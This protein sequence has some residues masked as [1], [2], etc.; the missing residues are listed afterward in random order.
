MDDF[1]AALDFM[2]ARYPGRA[3]VGRRLLVRRVGRADGRRARPSRVDAHRHRAA[4][5]QVRLRGVSP[6]ARSRSSSSTAR[7]DEICPLKAHMRAFYATLRRA[8]GAGGH[9]RRRPPV[10]RAGRAKSAT[11]L[12]DSARRDSPRMTTMTGRRHRLR[13]AHRRSARRRTARC[14]P[15]APTNSPRS[16]SREALR[17]A[18]GLDPAEIDDVILGCAMPEAEQG[19]N[20]ARI[21]SLRA[22][23]PVTRVGRHGEPLL[24]VRPAGDRLR[25]RAHHVRLRRRSSIAGGTESMS[26]VPMGGNKVAPNPALVDTLPG[27]VP[28][29]RA[30][31]PRTTRAS[32]RSRARSRTRSRSRSH[33]RALAAIDAGRFADEIVP[34]PSACVRPANGTKPRSTT[35]CSRRRGPAARHLARGAREAAA[36]VPRQPAPSRPA[37]RRR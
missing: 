14:A 37:T 19:L 35:S 30:S 7:R 21:A 12:E 16:S 11:P 20:V 17:R 32:R 4:G 24:L 23:V 29:H 18:P 13:R 33:Q 25:R 28:Q 8:E 5:R 26:L 34:V 9:R 6:R 3:A 31:S 10:R 1:R 22:G 2:A 27:R 36:G 15:R